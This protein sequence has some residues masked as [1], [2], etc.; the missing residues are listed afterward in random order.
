MAS[1]VALRNIAFGECS[2]AAP[3]RSVM[4]DGAVP[5]S[6]PG[7]VL[8]LEQATVVPYLTYR[9]AQDGMTVIRL[10][11]PVYGDPNRMIGENILHEERMNA[12]FLC[13]NAGK[14]G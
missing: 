5:S 10:E 9:L 3:A 1:S 12:Y 7:P 14:K 11:H 13:I 4:T 2:K 6:S 8:S